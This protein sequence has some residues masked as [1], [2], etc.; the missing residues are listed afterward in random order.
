M[1]VN[2]ITQKNKMKELEHLFNLPND[3]NQYVIYSKKINVIKNG[4]FA[5]STLFKSKRPITK[6]QVKKY[7]RNREKSYMKIDKVYL[8]DDG[9]FLYGSIGNI[10]DYISEESWNVELKTDIYKKQDYDEENY[11]NYQLGGYIKNHIRIDPSEDELDKEPKDTILK[12]TLYNRKLVKFDKTN[13][14]YYL[15]LKIYKDGNYM[16][17]FLIKNINPINEKHI[18]KAVNYINN[19]KDWYGNIYN[20]SLTWENAILET[21]TDNR[22]QIEYDKHL[23]MK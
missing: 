10:E 5:Y 23:F 8:I 7:I 18:V 20:L 1:D 15:I 11:T 19:N 22:Y 4:T 21:T 2:K 9:G 17:D 3:A 16:T 13:N 12:K 6:K 14:I